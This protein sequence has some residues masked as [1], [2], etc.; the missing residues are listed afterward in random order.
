MDDVIVLSDYNGQ[1]SKVVPTN[2]VKA[3]TN[4]QCSTV[5]KFRLTDRV[6]ASTYRQCSTVQKFR[7][8]DRVK[9]PNKWAMLQFLKMDNVI[10]SKR[11]NNIKVPTNGTTVARWPKILQN[12]YNLNLF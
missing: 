2:S 12:N 1:C 11:M 4:R 9:V 6:K 8:T 3:S 7:L 10:S 5:Q